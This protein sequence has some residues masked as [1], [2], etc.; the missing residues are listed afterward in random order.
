MLLSA[1]LSSVNTIQSSYRLFLWSLYGCI[2]IISLRFPIKFTHQ[3]TF[4]LIIFFSAA[5]LYIG[6]I[7][8]TSLFSFLSDSAYQFILPSYGSHNHLGDLAGLGISSLVLSVSHPFFTALLLIFG[9]II[10][11]LSYSKS[12]FLGVIV[13]LTIIAY[14]KRGKY[15]FL[16]ILV[17]FFSLCIVGIYTRELS[18]IPLV[19]SSQKIMKQ[20]FNLNSKP[21]L[22]ARDYYFPQVIRA[23][24]SS[25]VEQLFFGYGSGNYIYPSVKTGVTTDLTPME[26]HNIILSIFIEN[27]GLACFWFVVF[28]VSIIILGIKSENESVYLFIFLLANFQTDWT[29]TMPFFMSMLF[30]FAGQSI[31]QGG[32]NVFIKSSLFIQALSFVVILSGISGISHIVVQ[33]NKKN[34]DRQLMVAYENINITEAER[35]IRELELITPYEEKELVAWSS[36]EE[37]LGNIPEAIRFLEKLSIYSPRWYILYLP[38]QLDLQTRNGVDLKK[39]LEGREKEFDAFSLTNDEKDKLNSICDE[40]AN[41][42]CIR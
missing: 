23:W 21:L 15:I 11:A 35:I 19:Q 5:F 33:N 22:S 40:Y 26:T 42:S 41:I 17:L 8:N 39:Y 18:G 16:Y 37:S 20:R 14:I 25:P 24:K 7:F 31:H 12:A 13:T 27:G 10:M 6:H 30:F 36:Y 1:L 28:C 32:K 29:Y 38:H 2:F 4:L 3:K 9:L 34:L